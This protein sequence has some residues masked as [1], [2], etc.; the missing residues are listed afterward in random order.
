MPSGSLTLTITE[1]AAELRICRNS[2]YK[3][4]R[5]GQ[6]KAI[7]V[8]GRLRVR[9]YDLERYLQIQVQQQGNRHAG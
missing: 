7:R 1:V 8:L 6:I 2:V 4:I 3:L 9:R 5:T